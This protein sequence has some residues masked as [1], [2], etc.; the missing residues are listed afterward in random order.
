[1]ENVV[2]LPISKIEV[3]S[4]NARKIDFENPL[5]RLQIEELKQSIKNLGQ[6]QP[7]LVRPKAN[8]LYEVVVGERR[9]HAIR[10]LAEEGAIEGKI[11]ATVRECD[12]DTAISAM[13]AEN[14]A[15]A[16][17]S[18]FE[19]AKSY[20]SFLATNGNSEAAMHELSSKTGK[21]ISDIR[22]KLALLKLPKMVLDSWQKG[23]ISI[24][25]VQEFTRLSDAEDIAKALTYA[26]SNKLTVKALK[27][28][29]ENGS[30]R[31]KDA[32]F[33]K[34]GCTQCPHNGSLQLDM[35]TRQ[36][37]I[38]NGKCTNPSCFIEKQRDEITQRWKST[39]VAQK[40]E[41]NTFIFNRE[42]PAN[43]RL[44]IKGEATQRCKECPQ[45]GTIVEL[46][47]LVVAP[48]VCLGSKQ[49]YKEQY[50]V[51]VAPP[52]VATKDASN[53]SCPKPAKKPVTGVAEKKVEASK[54]EDDAKET[55]R[56]ERSTKRA[57]LT[58]EIFLQKQLRSI[59]NILSPDKPTSIKSSIVAFGLCN[60][61]AA[62]V[63]KPHGIE[64]SG[65]LTWKDIEA[66]NNL[67][68]E[69]LLGILLEMSAQV[70]LNTNDNK[71]RRSFARVNGI[72]AQNS[73]IITEEYLSQ[74]TK[75]ELVRMGEEVDLFNFPEAK[76]YREKHFGKK[77]LM[78]LKTG[79]LKSIILESG[80][81]LSGIV[82]KELSQMLQN[83]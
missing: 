15:R 21:R 5:K 60:T 27:A 70:I 55:R 68:N 54:S 79:E 9:Y 69:K 62:D 17:L 59:F 31:L 1:M 75:S 72:D 4:F 29:I 22:Q 35:F 77:A 74:M 28:F 46:N 56:K 19:T 44:V 43:E 61:N 42:I 58:C 11:R 65:T 2:D 53:N 3:S 32:I 64:C 6:I 8:G 51:V 33:C 66:V 34:E 16:D 57:D 14:T 36:E 49:C 67:P 63:L 76:T 20:E 41:T 47:C 48:C 39:K 24:G 73:T 50:E 82:P 26:L 23:D 25:H 13:L 78:S 45:F 71:V 52:Q 80:I 7:I 37:D 12:D 38:E 83:S 10:M 81:D 40:Y 30:P 18:E